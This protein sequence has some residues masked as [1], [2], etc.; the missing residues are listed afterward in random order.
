MAGLI[1][2]GIGAAM[3]LF[4]LLSLG[5]R[6]MEQRRLELP[7]TPC[8][9]SLATHVDIRVEG[10]VEAAK[11][12]IAPLSGEECVAYALTLY[13]D[14]PGALREVDPFYTP[15]PSPNRT[16]SS[17]VNSKKCAR[18]VYVV[19]ASGECRVFLEG[20]VIHFNKRRT[21][22]VGVLGSEEANEI[23]NSLMPRGSL[24]PQE[25]VEERL[26]LDEQVMVIGRMDIQQGGLAGAEDRG[27]ASLKADTPAV[28]VWAGGPERVQSQTR[29][30]DGL[31][32]MMIVGGI[33]VAFGGF[34]VFISG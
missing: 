10:R 16:A 17:S 5:G 33:V 14:D 9:D 23:A 7:V 13:F 18:E 21:E 4:G 11:P 8:G 34:Y 30:A 24:V 12:V 31:G 26:D 20:A 22:A 28:E 2:L 29:S 32:I 3:A 6:K 25:L 27:P 15:S 1:I 19:D